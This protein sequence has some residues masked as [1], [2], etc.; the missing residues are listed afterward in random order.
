MVMAGLDRN[1]LRGLIAEILDVDRA[2]VTDDANFIEDL[3]VD[4]LMA[5]EVMVVL[6]RTYGVKLDE[7]Q[8]KEMTSLSAVYELL[9]ASLGAQA[10][11]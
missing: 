11:I 8:L 5:L 4:S 1:E 3:G 7:S 2:S 6:E 9:E 10:A